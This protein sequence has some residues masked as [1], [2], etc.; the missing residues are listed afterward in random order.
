MYKDG[1]KIKKRVSK[2]ASLDTVEATASIVEG[3]A[4]SASESGRTEEA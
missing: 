2:K 4:G 1:A 3:I